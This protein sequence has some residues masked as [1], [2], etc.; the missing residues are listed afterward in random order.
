MLVA[1]VLVSVV[2]AVVVA[3][4]SS[5][6]P[7]AVNPAPVKTVATRSKKRT[8]DK[9]T[10]GVFNAFMI[11]D[12]F[13]LIEVMATAVSK[14]PLH[15]GGQQGGRLCCCLRSNHALSFNKHLCCRD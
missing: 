14:A 9:L 4:A 13:V 10:E 3:V 1:V 8:W 2:A 7:H 15:Q 5:P 6:P 11:T 12:V